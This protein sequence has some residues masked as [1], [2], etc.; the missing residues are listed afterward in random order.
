MR[1]SCD[2]EAMRG[3]LY[4]CLQ[5]HDELKIN[6]LPNAQPLIDIVANWKAA[7]PDHAPLLLELPHGYEL[8]QPSVEAAINIPWSSLWTT[9]CI[10]DCNKTPTFRSVVAA[11]YPITEL[12]WTALTLRTRH[13][14]QDTDIEDPDID[15]SPSAFL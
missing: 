11:L 12:G 10:A 2:V 14:T 13:D 4:S 6:W 3:L 1:T 8:S 15:E 5:I 7:H 9:Y